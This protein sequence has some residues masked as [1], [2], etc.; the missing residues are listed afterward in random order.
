MVIQ[1]LNQGEASSIA[2]FLEPL[3][4]D[5]FTLEEGGESSSD[6]AY[7]NENG[8]VVLRLICNSANRRGF[9]T[10]IMVYYSDTKSV[11]WDNTFA[12]YAPNLGIRFSGGAVL[13]KATMSGNKIATLETHSPILVIGKT[14]TGKTSFI[15][16]THP[17]EI[18]F[19]TTG[20]PQQSVDLEFLPITMG[21]DIVV[22]DSAYGGFYNANTWNL[23][24]LKSGYGH[25]HAVSNV[26]YE[27]NKTILRQIPIVGSTDSVEYFETVFIPESL[28]STS[29]CNFT[30]DGKKYG[31][32][33]L[34]VFEDEE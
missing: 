15:L 14:N 28:Q 21:D 10:G 18:S 32:S 5:F 4:P 2:Q 11:K 6:Y 9:L 8:D 31:S 13:M 22:H 1:Q 12:T 33:R 23:S 3:C 16:N 30:I 34:F 17:Y 19:S 29:C 26:R 27:K 20:D 7:K 25:R 24:T